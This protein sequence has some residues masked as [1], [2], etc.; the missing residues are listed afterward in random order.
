MGLSHVIGTCRPAEPASLPQ[1]LEASGALLVA[2]VQTSLG[3]YAAR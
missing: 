1:V 2:M 3:S